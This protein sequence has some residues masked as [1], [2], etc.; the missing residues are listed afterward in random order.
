MAE[1]PLPKAASEEVGLTQGLPTVAPNKTTPTDTPLLNA[2]AAKE[3]DPKLNAP[4]PQAAA[5]FA[6]MV[7]LKIGKQE[8]WRVNIRPKWPQ[9]PKGQQPRKLE[10]PEISQILRSAADEAVQ[11]VIWKAAQDIPVMFWCADPSEAYMYAVDRLVREFHLPVRVVG[12]MREENRLVLAI[13]CQVGNTSMDALANM[14][15]GLTLP[16]RKNWKNKKDKRTGA[17]SAGGERPGA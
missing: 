1:D 6:D 5:S 14:L 10:K 12:I 16:E 13:F 15:R 2:M 3:P 4:V 7:K 11:M 8:V 17:S 9:T